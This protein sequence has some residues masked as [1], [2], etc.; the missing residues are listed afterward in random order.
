MSA[1]AQQAAGQSVNGSHNVEVRVW[2]GFESADLLSA[3]VRTV[4]MVVVA[5]L[6]GMLGVQI[7]EA[8]NMAQQSGA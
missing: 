1:V 7:L 8:V 6:V 4:L 5:V 2:F 3:P